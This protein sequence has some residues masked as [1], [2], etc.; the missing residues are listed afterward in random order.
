MY[1]SLC[2][3]FYRRSS[4]SLGHGG[5]TCIKGEGLAGCPLFLGGGGSWREGEDAFT[6]HS[7]LP[8]LSGAVVSL[9]VLLI[10]LFDCL[11]LLVKSFKIFFDPAKLILSIMQL[12]SAWYL[13][14]RVQILC[15]LQGVPGAFL[16]LDLEG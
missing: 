7:L 14:F 10:G 3:S 9:Q 15:Q 1:L 6:D 16:V 13:H 12:G 4:Y 11:S 2:C 8:L 5:G